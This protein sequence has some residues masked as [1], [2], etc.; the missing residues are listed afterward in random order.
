MG[1]C[2]QGLRGRRVLRDPEKLTEIAQII[3]AAG[4]QEV[5]AQ[6]PEGEELGALEFTSRLDGVERRVRFDGD[7]VG[8][9]EYRALSNNPE[10]LR[11]LCSNEFRV[12]KGDEETT[13]YATLQEALDTLY[14]SARRNL[15]I[16][17][18]KGLGEMNPGQLWETTMDPERRRLLQV[19]IED[20]F[21]TDDIFSVLMGDQ[22]EPRREFIQ[23]NA[24][25]VTNLDI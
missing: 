16:Q 9:A 22:V 6:L 15:T 7:L 19:R 18:Y 17:R 23:N 10:G 20:A 5:S 8:A 24:L 3:E 12:A 11:T 14:R 1:W 4:F 25:A 13:S 2:P 21:T